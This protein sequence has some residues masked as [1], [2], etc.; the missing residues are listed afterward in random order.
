MGEWETW[1]KAG[2]GDDKTDIV[3]IADFW[4]APVGSSAVT[5]TSPPTAS[6]FR[7]AEMTAAAATLPGTLALPASG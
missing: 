7:S 5:A 6:L 4:S 1:I 3:V 2:T